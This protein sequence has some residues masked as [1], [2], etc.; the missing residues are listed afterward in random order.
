MTGTILDVINGGGIWLLV[1]DGGGRIVNQA[2][3][4]RYMADIVAD[5]GLDSPSDLIG[6]PVE[7]AADG[8]SISFPEEHSR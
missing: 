6:R 2:V 3:E 4:A 1:V 7:I 5:E 8:M